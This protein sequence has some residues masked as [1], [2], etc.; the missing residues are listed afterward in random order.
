MLTRNSVRIT[1]IWRRENCIDMCLWHDTHHP[2]K[3]YDGF[4]KRFRLQCSCSV[5]SMCNDNNKCVV[6]KL[7]RWRSF[8]VKLSWIVLVHR[9]HWNEKTYSRTTEFM[10][11]FF[12][13][14]SNNV[15]ARHILFFCHPLE[16][17]LLHSYRIVNLFSCFHKY[18]TLI[19]FGMEPDYGT[20]KVLPI[21]F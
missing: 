6:E 19:E 17:F 18:R 7:W 16:T 5:Y 3:H 2:S 14:N 1:N 11:N 15:I 4:F 8:Y 20:I 9:A 10:Q 12:H 21:F 13:R